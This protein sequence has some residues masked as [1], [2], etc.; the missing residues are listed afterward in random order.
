[1]SV[2]NE[3]DGNEIL[4]AEQQQ[5]SLKMSSIESKMN[6]QVKQYMDGTIN[7]EVHNTG[8]CFGTICV[9]T[10]GGKSGM[11]IRDMIWH[12]DHAKHGE[13]MILNLSA[14]MLNLC[15]QLAEDI[16]SVIKETHK[17]RCG[18]GEFAIFI[19]SS[20]EEKYYK[21]ESAN[22]VGNVYDFGE[23]DA[24]M[25][26]NP[27][28]RVAFVISCHMSLKYFADRV[29]GLK[30]YYTI[31]NYLDESH[32]LINFTQKRDFVDFEDEEEKLNQEERSR[33]SAMEMLLD[34]NYLY[35]F[36]ATPDKSVTRFINKRKQLDANKQVGNYHIYEISPIELIHNGT[37][38]KPDIYVAQVKKD[39]PINAQVAMSFM[40]MCKNENP[41]I[42]HK[43]LISCN[44]SD[45]IAELEGELSSKGC[46]VFSTCARSGARSNYLG[47]DKDYNG[48]FEEISQSEFIEKVDNYDGDCYVL[49]IRQ[50]RAGIDIKT[51]TDCIIGN[52][53][54][55]VN[56][57][58][59]VIYVQTIGRI[60][61]PYAGA[62]G[63]TGDD[64][65]KK[66]GNV[67]FVIGESD[68]ETISRQTCN[69]VVAY[70]GLDGVKAF[71]KEQGKDN[72]AIGQNHEKN[73]AKR[74]WDKDIEF[75]IQEMRQNVFTFIKENVFVMADTMRQLG[76]KME[77]NHAMD[78]LHEKFGYADC[79]NPV[80]NLFSDYKLM[81]E[82]SNLLRD[83]GIK[84]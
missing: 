54:T 43:V 53:A 84:E 28:I 4:T 11:V 33:K 80:G 52:N 67:L 83:Y 34:S 58:T 42:H 45:N 74:M 44:N 70:Y 7:Y 82:V 8:E 25:N 81:K 50:L 63:K 13:R 65:L 22:A 77:F 60:L 5:R 72:G 14:P 16:F 62:R 75:E 68:Y 56:D 30:K 21:T 38:V 19:N 31:M 36:S 18:N 61:R 46:K 24:I 27:S 57:G 20:A 79:L 32:V 66:K 64:R 78:M 49:H 10:G 15:G 71:S 73:E 51:L 37:I 26:G 69:F 59:K 40:E 3:N 6:W 35:C 2:S 47:E 39:M 55:R 23:F 41:N 12:I 9:P 17:V 1:M 48:N 76:G 29:K